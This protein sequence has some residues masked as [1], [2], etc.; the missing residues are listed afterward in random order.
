MK[1]KFPHSVFT[2]LVSKM[3]APLSLKTYS[4]PINRSFMS[5]SSK[6]V[7]II[8]ITVI[9]IFLIKIIGNGNKIEYNPIHE[10]E[11]N[12]VCNATSD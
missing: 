6:I 1:K 7:I 9:I 5:N 4:R 2:L 11:T 10:A 8:M 12:S 3:A